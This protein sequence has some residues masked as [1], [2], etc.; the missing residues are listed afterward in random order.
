M[1]AWLHSNLNPAE[2]IINY[3]LPKNLVP[4]HY[5]LT[6][7]P[8]FNATQKPEF[9][10]AKEKIQFRCVN[11]TKKFVIHIKNL[12]ITNNSLRISSISDDS[13]QS[14]ENFEWTYDN[15][16]SF[17]TADLGQN[18][19]FLANQNYMFEAEFKGFTNNDD[20]GFYRTSYKDDSNNTRF[21]ECF[22]LKQIS[23]FFYINV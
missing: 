16:T 17:F 11:D 8:F 10:E 9:Y 15:V 13:F 1:H 23:E 18:Q 2:P 20:L 6:I 7:Q 12:E 22:V 14:I 5:D 19:T 21:L 3:R 4:Y